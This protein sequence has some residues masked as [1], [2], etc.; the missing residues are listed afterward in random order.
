M[1]IKSPNQPASQLSRIVFKE[2]QKGP[3]RGILIIGL[4]FILIVG[5]LYIALF[6]YKEALQAQ[7]REVDNNVRELKKQQRTGFVKEVVDL[8][9]RLEVLG[10]LKQEHLYWSQILALLERLTLP[11][12][13]FKNFN[14]EIGKKEINMEGLT[15]NYTN[16]ARQL[17]VF[18]DSDLIE[19]VKAGSMRLGEDG[20]NFS[21]V[22]SLN[23]AAWKKP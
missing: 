5:G 14:S 7:L 12:V 3:G 13:Q 16:L 10:L 6:S 9:G 22:I 18:E 19:K 15:T 4:V 21:I 20:L 23:E 11:N 2:T 1:A 17:I 8:Q